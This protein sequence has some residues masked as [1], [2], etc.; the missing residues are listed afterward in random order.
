MAS[1]GRPSRYF[2]YGLSS[3]IGEIPE[4]ELSVNRDGGYWEFI[5]NTITVLRSEEDG[6]QLA[7]RILPL[8][9]TFRCASDRPEAAAITLGKREFSLIIPVT[10]LKDIA[11]SSASK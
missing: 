1:S 7:N 2:A 11:E 6:R 10:A 5:P 8:S 3:L 4:S 9:C